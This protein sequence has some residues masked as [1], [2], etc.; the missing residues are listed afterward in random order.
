MAE[1]VVPRW[2]VEEEEEEEEKVVGREAEAGWKCWKHPVQTSYGVCPACLHDRLLRLCPD[3]ANVR[4][5]GCFPSPSSSASSSSLSSAELLDSGAAVGAVGLVSILVDSEPAFRRSRSVGFPLPR[6][7]S[8]AVPDV[9]SVAPL[10]R[11]RQG[12]KGWA[13]FWPFLREARR[14]ESSEAEM[15]R[16]RSV[17]A[18]RSEAPAGGREKEGKAKGG[19]W[20]H[21]PSP[22][23]VFRHWKSATKVM[24]ERLPLRR[25]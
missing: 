22:M 17:A 9:D 13:P 14:K 25:R 16:S 20:W 3:C 21:F 23:R 12:R 18:E 24:Q 19:R 2:G 6:S 11:A 1:E 5:C 8:A 10:P 15:Y 7:R 4:P